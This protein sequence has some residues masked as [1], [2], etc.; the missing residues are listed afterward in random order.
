VAYT[1]SWWGHDLAVLHFPSGNETWVYDF[2]ESAIQQ[3]PVWSQWTWWNTG[4]ANHDRFR[5]WVHCENPDGH[6]VGDWETGVIYLMDDTL[7]SDGGNPIVW[8]RCAPHLNNQRMMQFHS[9]FMVD[10]ETGLGGSTPTAVL[11]WSDDGGHTFGTSLPMSTGAVGQYQTRCR[12]AGNLGQTRDRLYR[13][14]VSNTVP[15]RPFAAYL[16][17]QPGTN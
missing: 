6:L 7:A 3:I 14:R 1:L 12:V 15:P 10:Q 16:T 8:E 9:E 17:V 11:D 5:G 2:S 4:T 13:Y